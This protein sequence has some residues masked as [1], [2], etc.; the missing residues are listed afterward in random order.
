MAAVSIPMW[1]HQGVLPPMNPAN[2]TSPERSPYQASLTDLILRFATSHDRKTILD[3]FLR[4]RKELHAV[5]LKQGFQWL[6]G[7][8]L[9]NIEGIED[10]SPHD[11]DVI[12]FFSLP[13]HQTQQNLFSA[14]PRIFTPANNKERYRIDAYFVELKHKNPDYLIRKSIY[15]YSLWSHRRNDLWKGYLQVDLSPREDEAAQDN[16]NVIMAIGG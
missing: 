12:T 14:N 15:W 11:L 7:S 2:P 5:G 10:R 16:L 9:E 8:F 1:N 4:F 13:H 6:D 3:G